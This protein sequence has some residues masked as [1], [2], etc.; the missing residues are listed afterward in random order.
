MQ[1]LIFHVDVNSAFLS[2]EAA[3]R[4]ANGEKDIRLIPSAIGGS[5]D[6]RGSVILA[7]SVSAKKQ[8][9]KTGEP[10]LSA[11]RKCPGLYLAK[12]D[13][14]LYQQGSKAFMDVCI[15]YSAL[16]EQYSIDECFM[17]ITGASRIYESPVA[18]AKTLR[19]DI[20]A[21]LGITVNIGIGENKLL[22]KM[23]GGFEGSNKIHTLFCAELSK[24]LWPLPVGA[25]FSVGRM[26]AQRLEKAFIRTIGDLANAPLQRV[27][28]AVGA[29]VG[30]QIQSYANGIDNSPVLAEP[31]KAKGYSISTTLEQ[32]IISTDAAYKVLLS[33]AD[34]VTAR[35]R[36][37]GARAFGV[38]VTIR[39]NSFTDK[40][41]Q[42]K[43]AE[44]TDITH[45]VYYLSKELFSKLWDKKTPL[46]LLG[47]SLIDITREHNAQQSFFRDE[48]KERQRALDKTIDNIR[49]KFGVKTI[50]RGSSL[51]AKKNK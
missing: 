8:G 24:K 47:I 16:V 44:P 17:D 40:S 35:M 43:L 26:T 28:R 41:R 36:A 20:N 49:D 13:F 5:G 3:K 29:N 51:R 9:V 45:E 10:V 19:N 7:K 46:R 48:Q 27:Q 34:S 25:L 2:W 14:L 39:D 37:D 23:A 12:P 4:V 18:M 22:A 1:R 30:L 31:R 21:T 42:R 38:S 11:L 32:D 15:K 50:E 33:L 6:K